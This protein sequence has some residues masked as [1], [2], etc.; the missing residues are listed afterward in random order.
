MDLEPEDGRES[1]RPPAFCCP[2]PVARSRDEVTTIH[3]APANSEVPRASAS[4]GWHAHRYNP[5]FRVHFAASTGRNDFWYLGCA[6][7]DSE[8]IVRP[9]N[10]RSKQTSLVRPGRALRRVAEWL[11]APPREP[12]FPGFWNR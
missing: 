2:Y 8:P 1:L 3:F 6:V 11:R 5:Y 7:S 4:A 12:G 10:E 9:W